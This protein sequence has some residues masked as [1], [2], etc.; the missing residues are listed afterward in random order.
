[1]AVVVRDAIVDDAEGIALAQVLG[2]RVAYAGLMPDDVLAALDPVE[3]AARLR[4]SLA[5]PDRMLTTLAAVADGAVVGFAHIGDYHLDHGNGET[6]PG[7]GEVYGIYV[8]P[9]HWRHGAG[10]ALLATSVAR[11]T[12]ARARPVRLWVLEANEPSRRFYERC[13]FA[14]D[15]ATGRFPVE[16]PGGSRVELPMVRYTHPPQG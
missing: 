2:W 8:H 10:R 4:R 7:A 13:G 5:D 1:M 12:Q 3:R 15:G 9:D 16:R 14:A 6:D 11:L